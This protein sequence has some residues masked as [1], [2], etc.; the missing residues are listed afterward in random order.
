MSIETFE[1]RCQVAA[2]DLE[3]RLLRHVSSPHDHECA[4]PT[5]W[6]FVY[7]AVTGRFPWERER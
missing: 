7:R 4:L 6:P 3:D 5:L 2:D 1:R